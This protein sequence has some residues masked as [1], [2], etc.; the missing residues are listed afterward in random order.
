MTNGQIQVC[1]SDA[2]STENNN[3]TVR[4]SYCQTFTATPDSVYFWYSYYAASSDS[5]AS[6]RVYIHDNYD[7]IDHVNVDMSA[8]TNR[9]VV[10][11][12]TR[13][14]ST[15]NTYSWVQVKEPFVLGTAS[16][17]YVLV[18]LASNEV[19]EGGSEND[20]LSIDDIVFIY[21]AWATGI[22][23]A[24]HSVPNFSK[25]RFNYVDSVEYVS[26]LA[27]ISDESFNVF[28]EV[29]DVTKNIDV[30]E[31][32]YNGR[33]AKEATIT[34][35]AE[36][37]VTIKTYHVIIYAV[38]DDPTFYSVTATASPA[39]GGT[40]TIDPVGGL[41]AGGSSI[42]LT[43]T[44]S[45]GYAFTQWNDGVTTNPRT[46]TVTDNADY[47]AQFALQQFTITA[48]ASPAGGGTVTGGGTYDYNAVA[49]LTAT[50]STGYE[51]VEWQD[52]NTENPRTISVT[53]NATYTATFQVRNYTVTAVPNNALWGSV[54]GAGTYAHGASATVEATPATDYHFVRWSND[55]TSNP[56]T[57]TVTNNVSLT[58][59]FE[60][61]VI[62]YYDVTVLTDNA[63]MGSVSGTASVREGRTTEISATANEGYHFT[64]W[65]D[66]NTD[67]PRTVTVTADTTF[68][69]SFAPNSYTITVLSA[70]E[71]MG[72]VTGGD[73]YL[74]G[75][76]A[77]L[78]ATPLT[79]FQ[80]A[81][82][83][84]HN[85]EATRQVAVTGN[86]TYTASFDS[87]MLTVT[88]Q[89]NDNAFGTVTGSGVYF[90]GSEVTL[91]AT[92]A[93]GYHFVRWNNGET[94]NP[95]I[96]SNID[97]NIN[98]TAI[99]EEDGAVINYYTVTA[100]SANPTMGTVTG[101]GDYEENTEATLTATAN[102]GYEF[103]EWNDGVTTNPRTITVTSD[104][105]FTATF[106]ARTFE[107]TVVATP[108]EG[109][110]VTGGD[111][112]LYNAT[113]TLTATANPGYEFTRWS[114][115]IMTATR[116]VTVTGAAT[117]TAEF[118]QQSYQITISA[119]NALYGATTGSGVYHYGETVTA[120]ATPATGY[121]FVR[122]NNGETA[123]P[124]TFEAQRNLTLIAIFDAQAV[125]YYTVTATSENAQQGTVEG[126]GT[127]TS[128]STAT[129]NA[130]A[131]TG[132]HFVEWNDGVTTNPRTITVTSD[133]TFT[134]SF[135][136]NTYTVQLA[137]NDA[138]MGTVD[139]EGTYNYMEQVTITATANPGYHFVAWDNGVAQET[140]T[141]PI[142]GDVQ[143]TAVF[144]EDEAV[145]YTITVMS[146]DEN[147]GQAYGGGVYNEGDTIEIYAVAAPQYAF[148]RWHDDN[149]SNPRT[150][151]VTGNASYMAYFQ[152]DAAIF[153][154]PEAK[155]KAWSEYGRLFV[156]GVEK[157]NVIITDMMG[158][159][160]YRQNDC[161]FDS[162]NIAVPTTGIYLVHADG[163]S[164]KKVLVKK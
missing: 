1:S 117:Y 60:M 40:A 42:T 47:V 93:D 8:H 13:T 3:K 131:A 81:E 33:P 164:T 148:L 11:S 64:Q 105:A 98:V 137:V 88:A 123:N 121:Q 119:N 68:T 16:A 126:G 132:Y 122:W 22:D 111:T 15:R 106:Q 152:L 130:I 53:S 101:G 95:Y 51:F 146:A 30:T 118:T 90:Y 5:R 65:N 12:L 37:S 50:P 156:K 85:T 107:L 94:A 29:S 80:F 17:N 54:T 24:G 78:T 84:D 102:T 36:D 79:G 19:P 48:E 157:H 55:S 35:T 74:Y 153:E 76:T 86:A 49:T 28:T 155:V 2:E 96:I 10:R 77:T 134:A 147:R 72:T 57:F 150:I 62:N 25:T 41:Y 18:S 21:S 135:A 67:N 112:Y 91:T 4:G 116:T 163:V 44:P 103:V 161:Q 61:D 142:T 124:Y 144:A 32:T 46:V 158:R 110:V 45:T 113:A 9:K 129:L 139:G 140:Y 31:T 20:A 6:V 89:A 69:A 143:L 125:N 154:A 70:D 145:T 104:T 136:I 162:F 39:I 120:T 59:F 151:V 92:P 83:D 58:A 73:E 149:S 38:N 43:A 52:G 26:D 128:G 114:D 66:G 159:V 56:Y 133:T 27:T 63:V 109:G 82:W 99:F 100:T 127:Y 108:A 115:G 141:F 87:I 14:V 160:L 71:A 75:S 34:I 138:A 97:E 7:F 23:F